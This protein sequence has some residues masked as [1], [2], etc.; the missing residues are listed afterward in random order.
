MENAG[1]ALIREVSRVGTLCL[2][3]YVCSDDCQPLVAREAVCITH[4]FTYPLESSFNTKDYNEPW[5]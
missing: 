3:V 2:E 1:A 5:L 4:S